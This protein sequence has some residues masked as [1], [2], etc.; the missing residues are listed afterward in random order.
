[1][2]E[3]DKTPDRTA[4]LLTQLEDKEANQRLVA[5]EE[6]TKTDASDLNILR[7]LEQM[8]LKDRS[9]SVRAELRFPDPSSNPYLAFAGMLAAALDGV[10]NNLTPPKPLNNIN[11]YNLDEK[12]R[13]KHR[14]GELP[15]SLGESLAE[16]SKDKVLVEALGPAAYEAFFRAKSEEWGAYRLH[17]SDYEIK[18]Y[19][20]TA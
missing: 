9:K 8:A 18:R 3:M 11:L 4:E 15:G 12:G 2:E 13:K 5:I 1:M 7:K 17:V 10:E 16:L 14:V 19:L 20:E 6:I